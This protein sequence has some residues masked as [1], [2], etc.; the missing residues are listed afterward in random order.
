[1]AIVP[2]RVAAPVPAAC[3]PRRNPAI[4]AAA[5]KP[6]SDALKDA[7]G[8][9][10]REREDEDALPARALAVLKAAGL[11]PVDLQ[12]ARLLRA[13]RAARAWV[14]PVP[15]VSAAGAFACAPGT[16]GGVREG[17]AVVSLGGAPAGGNGARLDLV[18]GQA[19]ASVDLCAGEGHGMIGVSGIVPDGVDAVFIT[20]ADGTATRADVHDNGSTFVLARPARPEARYLVW[21]G[22]DGSPHVQPLPAVLGGREACARA[23]GTEQLPRVTPDGF[24][25]GCSA[26]GAAILAPPAVRVLRGRPPRAARVPGGPA[27]PARAV[28]VPRRP[29]PAPHGRSP[30]L[31]AAREHRGRRCESCP[32][33][34]PHA[35]R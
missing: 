15:Y 3:A 19:P 31:R 29:A 14:V 24:A 25:A 4:S 30:R 23:T 11:E 7:F 32:C 9:L 1:V 26:L 33:R 10:R 18:R 17:L 8:I 12:A 22:R 34:C 28:R 13:D 20:A 5:R 35:R 21:T 16:D 2:P 27:R 6:P